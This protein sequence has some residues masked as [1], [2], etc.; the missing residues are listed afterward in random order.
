MSKKNCLILKATP[1][2][3]MGLSVGNYKEVY[4]YKSKAGKER[5]RNVLNKKV[6]QASERQ[7][8]NSTDNPPDKLIIEGRFYL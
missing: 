8:D 6:I 1:Y 2:F 4:N 7:S 3:A 5:K